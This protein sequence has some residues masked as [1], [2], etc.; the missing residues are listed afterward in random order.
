MREPLAEVVKFMGARAPAQ[1]SM[2]CLDFVAMAC[3]AK[4]VAAFDVAHPDR[5]TL[6]ASTSITQL[7]INWTLERWKEGRPRLMKGEILEADSVCLVP[8][9]KDGRIVGLL[10]IE[11]AR[12]D[13]DALLRVQDLISSS[14]VTSRSREHERA[15]HTFLEATPPEEIE[16]Q[17][18][19]LLLHRWEWNLSRVAQEMGISRPTMYRRLDELGIKRKPWGGGY[20]RRKP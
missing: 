9:M 16:R 19:L 1:V 6:H 12:L 15:W 18:I 7:A 2:A 13:R 20:V 17:K 11:T 14:I 8:L 10:Y 5:P 3:A 4:S